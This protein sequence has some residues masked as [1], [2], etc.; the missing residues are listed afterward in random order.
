MPRII[1]RSGLSPAFP[2]D[3]QDASFWEALGRA[4]AAFG[5]LEWTL[6]RAIFALCGD[7]P[8]PEDEAERQAGLDAWQKDLEGALKA[9]IGLLAAGF[10][11][12]VTNHPRAD[13]D[14]A[15]QVIAD[16]RATAPLRNAICHACWQPVLAVVAQPFFVSRN[17]EVL[18]SKIDIDIDIAWLEQL[19]RHVPHWLWTLWTR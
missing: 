7:Q 1:D 5:F 15:A 19:H 13:K 17:L 2:T 18:E 6:Q 16:I 11:R 10:E 4:I 3:R 8:A 14:Y 9:T 12:A